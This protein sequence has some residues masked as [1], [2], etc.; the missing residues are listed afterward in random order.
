M[1]R[2][3]W[4][5]VPENLRVA[6]EARTGPISRILPAPTGNHADIASTL[7]TPNGKTFVKAARKLADRDGPEVRSL[8]A[9]AAVNPYVTRFAPRLLWHEEVGGWLALGFEHVDGRTADY[10]TSSRDLSIVAKM[11]QE[12]QSTAC[13][14]VVRMPMERRWANL[15]GDVSRMAGDALLHTDINPNNVL[16]TPDRCVYLVDWAFT[17]HG[18]AW[19]EP[20]Q[21]IPWLLLAGHSP[22]QAEDWVSQFPSW[23]DADPADIDLYASLHTELW[24]RRSEIYPEPWMPPYVAAIQRWVDHRKALA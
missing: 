7:E 18:A 5:Q 19:L 22:A 12:L 24:R 11:V 10:S 20:G 6:V 21:I 2:S 4:A 3:D 14:D 17:S 9:E 1:P 8:R 16:I 13:P 23:L 15:A